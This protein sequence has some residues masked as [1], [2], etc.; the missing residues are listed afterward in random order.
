MNII[1]YNTYLENIRKDDYSYLNDD[2]DMNRYDDDAHSNDYDGYDGDDSEIDEDDMQHLLYLLRTM[3]KNAGIDNV[4][5]HNKKLDITI[6][7]KLRK[8]ERL[9]DIIKVFE[10]A[11][12]LKKDILPQY[13]SEFDM[14]NQKDSSV[15]SFTFTYD[16]GL[17]DDNSPF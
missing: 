16:E 17:D 13:D 7:C 5:V 11:N 6:M 14:W 10:V 9:R 1:K 4:E 12:K 8:K 3:F 2:L 15:F